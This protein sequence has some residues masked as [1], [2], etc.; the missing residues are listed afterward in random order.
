MFSILFIIVP[1]FIAAV[2]VF[3]IA[4]IV[5]PKFKGKMMSREIKA[6]KYMI[7][8][9]KEDLKS[10]SDDMAY[11][12]KDGVKTTA[13][14]IREGLTKS[15]VFCKHCGCEIDDDSKFCKKC[16]KKQ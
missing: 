12:T 5:S 4:M 11:A 6:Q 8:E 7:E 14:A 9:S 16:G 2:F 10:I 1:I 15:T 13:G 3:I